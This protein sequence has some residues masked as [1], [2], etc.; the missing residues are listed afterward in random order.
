MLFFKKTKF[1]SFS[2]S[3]G[4]EVSIGGIKLHEQGIFLN[5]EQALSFS[6]IK[7]PHGGRWFLSSSISRTR[8][9]Q[10]K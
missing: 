6:E 8:S 9:C 2:S 10:K 5:E 3:R 7:T 1:L 4:I